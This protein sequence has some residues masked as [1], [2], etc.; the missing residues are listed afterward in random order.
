[1]TGSL[2]PFSSATD[3][4]AASCAGDLGVGVALVPEH[5]V[6]DLG[7]RERGAHGDHEVGHVALPVGLGHRGAVRGSR[8]V[9]ERAPRLVDAAL[10]VT[11]S[12]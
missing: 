1:M 7:R 2:K 9:A 6:D 3:D 4:A 10:I 8:A 11:S 12:M 5:V